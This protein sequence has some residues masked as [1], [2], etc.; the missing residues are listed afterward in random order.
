MLVSDGDKKP[1]LISCEATC[2]HEKVAKRI[3]NV[4]FTYNKNCLQG[5]LLYNYTRMIAYETKSGYDCCS[6]K[7]KR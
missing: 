4:R 2:V 5:F 3:P 6:E 7:R 1:H